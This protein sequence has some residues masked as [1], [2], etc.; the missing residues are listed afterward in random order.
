MNVVDI[1]IQAVGTQI[2]G[3]FSCNIISYVVQY[4]RFSASPGSEM[5]SVI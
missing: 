5:R 1:Y 3:F 2:S 4:K